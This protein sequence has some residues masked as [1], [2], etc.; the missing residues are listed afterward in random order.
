MDAIIT[1]IR[2]IMVKKKEG[3]RAFKLV[4]SLLTLAVLAHTLYSL[5]SANNYTFS[6]ISGKIISEDIDEESAINLKHRII[7][8][9]EWLLIIVIFMVSLIRAK[10]EVRGVEQVIVTKIKTPKGI[11]RTDLDMMY[12]LVKEK[13]AI[14]VN[15]LAKYFNVNDKTIID[16]ARILEEANLVRINYPAIGEPQ[17]VINKEEMNDG[18]Q[19]T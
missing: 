3:N 2:K 5:Y 8:A 16:W 15:V 1:T 6:G 9:G 19:T 17:I 18:A 4:A 13:K 12:D 11:A 7:L 14:K 10:M